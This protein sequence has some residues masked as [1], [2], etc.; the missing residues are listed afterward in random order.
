VHKLVVLPE[1]ALV[2]ELLSRLEA[3]GIKA[4]GAHERTAA[5][6]HLGMMS[7]AIWIARREDAEPALRVLRELQQ[8]TTYEKCP[9]C[10][11]DLT[12]H[13]AHVKCPECGH[14]TRAAIADVHCGACG[15]SVP[16]NFTE[17]WNCGAAM[18]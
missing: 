15:E 5:D 18:G 3:A 14:D 2:F 12:G 17:C 11:Y 16:A 6:L 8:R 1:S 9:E 10:G 7:Y 13:A 4:S